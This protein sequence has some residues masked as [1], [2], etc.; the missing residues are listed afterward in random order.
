MSKCYHIAA[1]IKVG[2]VKKGQKLIKNLDLPGSETSAEYSEIR[3]F[4]LRS[5]L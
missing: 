3:M 1:T 4:F 5:K 2:A